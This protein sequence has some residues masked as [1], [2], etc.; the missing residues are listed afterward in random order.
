MISNTYNNCKLLVNWSG[1]LTFSYSNPIALPAEV[2]SA[3]NGKKNRIVEVRWYPQDAY[4]TPSSTYPAVSTFILPD[5]TGNT[6]FNSTIIYGRQVSSSN[7][8]F[9][10]LTI[11]SIFGEIGGLTPYDGTYYTFNSGGSGSYLD[12]LILVGIRVFGSD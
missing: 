2:I 1:S 9:A 3:I 6:T 10:I 7:R 12:P 4:F 11:Y 5:G 8:Q